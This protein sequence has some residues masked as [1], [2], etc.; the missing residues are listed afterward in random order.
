MIKHIST[1]TKTLLISAPLLATM[2]ISGN[3]YAFQE[4]TINNT[5]QETNEN[6]HH[7]KAKH[8]F[9]K[10][11]KILQ[12]TDDQKTLMKAIHQQAKVD[13]EGTHSEMKAFKAQIKSLMDA[14]VFDEQAFRNV[15]SQYQATFEQAAL[16]KAKNKHAIEQ[17]L[18]S[19]QKDKW[20][21]MKEKS[22]KKGKRG[23]LSH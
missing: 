14:S 12:L 6:K 23:R 22:D 21:K 9:K 2:L 1:A 20:I 11:A 19:E 10:M 4:P 15:Y 5:A 3:S 8:H 18:T 7:K 13:S 17:I 16:L